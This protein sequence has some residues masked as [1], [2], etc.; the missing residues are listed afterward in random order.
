ME[1]IKKG[2]IEEIV[3]IDKVIKRM[4][5]DGDIKIMMD[6]RKEEGKRKIF[7]GKNKEE[8]VYVKKRLIDENKVKKKR[9]VNELVK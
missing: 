6:K 2:E 1:E 5:V 7:E 8:K 9:V 3:K 4:E